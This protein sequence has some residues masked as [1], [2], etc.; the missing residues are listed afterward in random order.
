MARKIFATIGLAAA[1][2]LTSAPLTATTLTQTTAQPTASTLEDR[3]EYRLE[4]NDVTRK[5]D[6]K[7]NVA[8]TVATLT[9]KVATDAQKAQAGKL[10]NVS[11]ITKV[12]NNI[13]IDKD[14]DRTLADRSKAGLQKT[15]DAITD[16]WITTKVKWFFM[17]DDVLKGS[18]IN[19]DTNNKV[20]TLKGT[21]P[22]TA[23]R[24]HAV[25]VA[26]MTEGVTRVVDALTLKS[27]N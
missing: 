27:G 20:V 13:T 5:Y 16:A 10:A 22:N 2:T 26:K 14:V 3:I 21:V 9:G 1:L 6:V 15:G 8:G 24:N 25:N 17:G 23:A 19:V 7:V 18:D 4:T 11:G 12:E